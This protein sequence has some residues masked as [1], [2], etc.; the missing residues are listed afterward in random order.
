MRARLSRRP[1]IWLL[2]TPHFPLS[3]QQAG[4]ETQRKTKRVR[5]LADGRGEKGVREEPNNKSARK[6]D[7]SRHRLF[8]IDFL[9]F[10]KRMFVGWPHTYPDQFFLCFIKHIRASFSHPLRF[11]IVFYFNYLEGRG[12]IRRHMEPAAER[13]LAA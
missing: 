8:V 12:S 11:L 6:L 2:P 10:Y 13:T 9:W 4:P 3:R 7:F 5:Q 1:M